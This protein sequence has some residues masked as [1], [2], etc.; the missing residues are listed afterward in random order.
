MQIF[1]TPDIS[2]KNELPEEEAIHAIRVLRLSEGDPLLLTDGRGFFYK[3][4]IIK[5]NPKH[6]EIA[7]RETIKQSPL[8]NTDLHI[9]IA[10]TKN[11]ER[12]EWFMEKSTEIGIDA[13]TC[14]LCRHS[15]RK[16]VK[17]ERLNKIMISAMK[18]SQK[19]YLPTLKGMMA[20]RDFITQP[21][22]GRKFIAHCGVVGEERPLLKKIYKPGENVRIAIGPEGDFSAEEV[23][24]AMEYGYEPVSLGESIF[25][26]ET[27]ALVACHTIR[28][29]N[30]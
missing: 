5:A 4:V 14:L 24:L 23:G 15:E 17:T 26:T 28:L 25:R 16:E 6:C 9:A 12:M 18:Q 20:F 13:V 11:M 21:Y 27:A 10:P 22:D 3:A 19:A 29:L 30:Q 1:Y 8:W 7:V 2:D